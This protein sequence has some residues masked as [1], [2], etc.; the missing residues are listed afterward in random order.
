MALYFSGERYHR[1]SAPNRS[2]HQQQRIAGI[3]AMR[4]RLCSNCSCSV[5]PPIEFLWRR[6]S[7]R[8]LA[9]IAMLLMLLTASGCG[10]LFHS[11][12]IAPANIPL[13]RPVAREISIEELKRLLPARSIVVG[14]D[15]DDTLIFSAPAFNAL[16]PGYPADVIRPKDYAALTPAQRRQYHEFWNRLNE[17]FDDRSIPKRIGKQLLDLHVQRGD[18]I[19]IISR[20][21]QTVPPTNT[22]TRRLERLFGIHLHHPVVQTNLNDKTPFIAARG[23]L[24]YYGDSD[25]DITAAVGARAVPIRVKRSPASYAK[26]R[27]HNGQLDEIVLENSLN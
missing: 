25:S 18:E 23:I 7:K 6:M 1:T 14:F 17:E 22:V 3:T 20:R 5:S 26:D 27:P 9:Q 16:E 8:L 15:V 24:Y 2:D 10:T 21:Q 12:R 4:R 19:Y 13:T 11:Q